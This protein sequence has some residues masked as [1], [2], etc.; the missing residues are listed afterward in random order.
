MGKLFKVLKPALTVL[1]IYVVLTLP[2]FSEVYGRSSKVAMYCLLVA[3]LAVLVGS[4]KD[5]MRKF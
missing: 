3:L 4:M 5:I 2:L 1:M